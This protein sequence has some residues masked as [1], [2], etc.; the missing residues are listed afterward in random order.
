MVQETTPPE[1]GGVFRPANELFDLSGHVAVVTGASSGLGAGFSRILT[2][3]GATVYAAARRLERLSELAEENDKIIPVRC[4][5]TVDADRQ[6]LV[7]QVMQESGRLDVLVNNAGIPGPPDALQETEE[8]F[9]NILDVNLISGFRLSAIA[10]GA[11]KHEN[12]P[13]AI[14]NVSSVIGMV[15]TAPIGG[16]GYS[17]SKSAVI[18]MTRELAGQWGRKGVRVNAVVPGWF[19][20]EMTDGLFSNDKSAGWVR[21]NTMLGRGGRTGEVD[22][23]LLFLASPA[24]SYVTGHVL[25]VD[26][27]WTAR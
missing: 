12:Q 15:S 10:V 20:T 16:A 6:A 3:A 11:R 9:K 24:A 27:G 21:R 7:D 25:A 4:D 23:A 5:V 26:G 8:D 14:I 13:M 18:G 17:A 19:D 22:G 1:A 2:N